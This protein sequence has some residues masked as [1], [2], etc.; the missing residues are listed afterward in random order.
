MVSDKSINVGGS[1]IGPANTGDG[2]VVNVNQKGVRQHLGRE[3]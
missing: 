1:F 2:A 3:K